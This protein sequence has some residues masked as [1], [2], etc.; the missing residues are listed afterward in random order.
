MIIYIYLR[1]YYINPNLKTRFLKS[2]E[3]EDKPRDITFENNFRTMIFSN[4]MKR[5][6]SSFFEFSFVNFKVRQ[7]INSAYENFECI[8]LNNKSNLFEKMIFYLNIY[9]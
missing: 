7:W 8:I 5:F 4:V 1:Y 3:N 6:F 2:N 9:G